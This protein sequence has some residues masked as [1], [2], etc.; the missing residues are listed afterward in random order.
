MTTSIV[1]GTSWNQVLSATSPEEF[2]DG[3]PSIAYLEHGQEFLI[4]IDLEW[5]A[6]IA[7]FYDLFG[8]EE[9][10][11][12]FMNVGGEILDVWGEGL[13]RVVIWGRANAAL[14]SGATQIGPL[15]AIPVIPITTAI[16]AVIIAAGLA[17]AIGLM[18][19]FFKVSEEVAGTVVML[20][21][22]VVVVM[23]IKMMGGV[24]GN[25]NENATAQG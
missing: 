13:Y 19:L 20:I 8:A 10:V 15:V 7:K 11:A 14:T 2:R 16:S 18:V 4:T 24:I 5:W 3:T 23:M 25:G 21:S 17:L 6:P 9:F 12:A 1:S 22:M